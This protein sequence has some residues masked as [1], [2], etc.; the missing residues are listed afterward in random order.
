MRTIDARAGR[1]LWISVWNS[2]QPVTIGALHVREERYPVEQRGSFHSNDALLNRIWQVGVDTLY[3]NMTDAY[4]DTPWRERGQ[5]WGDAFVGFQ[6]NRVAFGDALLFRRALRFM[7]E[8][9]DAEGKPSAFVPGGASVMLLDFGL[10]WVHALKEYWQ[11]TEDKELVRTYYPKLHRLMQY[12]ASFVHPQSGLLDMPRKHWSQI[13]FLDW[14]VSDSR[15]GQSTALNAIYYQSLRDAAVLASTVG[16]DQGAY[17]FEQRAKRV[18]SG[19]LSRLYMPLR[20]AYADT[21]L[22]GEP[23]P[24]SLQAQAWA[25][26]HGVVPNDLRAKVLRSL[27]ALVSLHPFARMHIPSTSSVQPYG[28]YWLLRALGESRA[29]AEALEVIRSYYGEMLRRGATTWWERFFADR[30]YTASYSHAWGGSPTWFLSTYILGAEQ[31][32]PRSWRLTPAW[33]VSMS[34]SGTLP[35]LGSSEELHVRWERPD[36]AFGELSLPARLM[37]QWVSLRLCR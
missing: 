20:R 8:G 36:C 15:Y 26:S 17:E 16:D 1:Y 11:L 7:G 35:L 2:T 25:I 19:L 21:L 37:A 3:P 28:M 33:V 27:N 23:L 29:Y 14:S 32:S 12:A 4:T 31:L 6:I 30:Y 18:L 5:W 10:L 24:P 13:A 9:I 34:V 22:E